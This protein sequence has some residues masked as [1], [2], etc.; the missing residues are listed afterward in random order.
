[1]NGN[2]N[3][4]HPQAGIVEGKDQKRRTEKNKKKVMEKK[5]EQR[6]ENVKE[7]GKDKGKDKDNGK[8][9]IVKSPQNG[10]VGDALEDLVLKL[11]NFLHMYLY[12]G[13]K[14]AIFN[15]SC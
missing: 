2:E 15:I 9:K 12:G 14:Q 5:N 3:L 7:N 13:S 4:C 11:P 10:L 6:K 1:M 8:K